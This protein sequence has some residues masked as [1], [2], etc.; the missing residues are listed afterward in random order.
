MSVAFGEAKKIIHTLKDHGYEAYI[1]GGAV[2]DLLLKMNASDIDIVTTA[3]ASEVQRIFPKTFQM[4]NQHET[5]IVR[6]HHE[7]FEVT[8]VRGDTV[9]DDLYLR[10]LT[11]NSLAWDKEGRLIDPT[12]GL[13]DLREGRLRTISP[14]DRMTEDP[15]RMLRVYRFVS[16]LGFTVD[17]ELKAAV[18]QNHRML[19]AVAV[20]RVVK[21]WMKLVKGKHRNLAIHGI[22]EANMLESIPGLT[23]T[24]NVLK[25]LSEMPTLETESELVCWTVFC[26]CQDY[27]DETPLKQLAL[28]N[29]LLRGIKLRLRYFTMRLREPWKPYALYV[30]TYEVASDVETL[31]ALFHLPATT[32]KELKEAWNELP[33]KKKDDLAITGRDLLYKKPGPWVKEELTWAEKAVVT[34]VIENDKEQLLQAIERR[35]TR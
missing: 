5:V 25:K 18:I 19:R 13:A 32:H 26:L 9:E 12:G 1:V 22:M 24:V 29:E 6:V 27:T 21:E 28:S 31:R 23:L 7:N 2:R 14:N 20:E 16:E 17:P 8:T 15:L 4:N 30:A 3:S 33:I 35:R 10:D 11:I 34:K